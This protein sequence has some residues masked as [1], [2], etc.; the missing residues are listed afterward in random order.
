MPLPPGAVRDTAPW[1]SP[2]A[3]STFS[4]RELR[5]VLAHELGHVGNRDILITW[6]AA[7]VA[8]GITFLANLAG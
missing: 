1:R 3:C 4:T 5:A 2:A 7:A 8:T 6:I